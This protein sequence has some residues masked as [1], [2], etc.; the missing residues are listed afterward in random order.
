MSNVKP[1][2]VRAARGYLRKKAK[3]GTKQINPRKFAAAANEQGAGFRDLLMFI[4]QLQSGGSEQ[5]VWRHEIL[6]KAV[7]R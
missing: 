6:K 5:G 3:A 4:S 7:T 1:A 2:E